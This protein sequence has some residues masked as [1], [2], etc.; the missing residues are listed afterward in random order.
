PVHEL[1]WLEAS[2]RRRP[3]Q[4]VVQVARVPTTRGAEAGNLVLDQTAYEAVQAHAFDAE[5][6]DL[7][8][9]RR[10]LFDHP[11]AD[12]AVGLQPVRTSLD[13]GRARRPGLGALLVPGGAPAVT[14]HNGFLVAPG[15]EDQRLQERK[16]V[17]AGGVLP[18]GCEGDDRDFVAVECVKQFQG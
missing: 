3:R 7:P 15:E 9:D 11:E 14:L 8:D 10:T 2:R 18:F 13:D 5:P 16:I 6:E 1:S 17:A 4:N 12:L